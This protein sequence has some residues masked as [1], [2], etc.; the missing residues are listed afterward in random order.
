[1]FQ[2]FERPTSR[3]Y[4]DGVSA[5]ATRIYGASGTTDEQYVA[6]FARGSIPGV[7]TTVA[8][9]LYRGDIRVDPNGHANWT[10]T[11]NYTTRNRQTGNYTWSFD[12]TGATV[13]VTTARQHVASFPADEANPDPH[14]GTIGVT[15]DGN[16]EGTDITIPVLKLQVQ[17][18]HPLGVVSLP[19]AKKLARLTGTTN[20]AAW[21]DSNFQAGEL[22][23]LGAQ[24]SD[25]SDAEAEL[26]YIF[27]ASENVT[28]LSFG[29]IS[30]VIKDGHHFAWVEYEDAVSEGGE[31]AT[32]AKRVHVEQVY[33]E[34]NFASE[35]GWG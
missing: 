15:K 25:G 2:F 26:N 4:V 34:A 3:P 24:G 27:A 31:A 9:I 23:F 8:G 19:F 13:R 30:N 33:G 7:I 11:A 35:F 1:M 18:K 22:L 5:T 6:A 28:D 32:K 17:F 16:V 20:S 14:K 10:V 29:A 21:L 12:T